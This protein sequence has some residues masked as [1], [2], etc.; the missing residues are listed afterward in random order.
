M[1]KRTPKPEINPAFVM[2]AKADGTAFWVPSRSQDICYLVER[3]NGHLHCSCPARVICCHMRAVEARLQQ[4]TQA[5]AERLAC[6]PR[7]LSGA[8]TSEADK[9]EQVGECAMCG[10]ETTS[11][12]E[13]QVRCRECQQLLVR[14]DARKEQIKAEAERMQA[15]RAAKRERAILATDNRAFSIYAS[16]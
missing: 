14:D 13:G 6:L 8:E 12:S 1:T 10:G 9:L 16:K 11:K 3:K 2:S 4:D 5:E 7:E 15:E